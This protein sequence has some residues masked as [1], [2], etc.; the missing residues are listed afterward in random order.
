[1]NR[2]TL[3]ALFV[4]LTMVALV[5]GSLP[6][7]T[8][9]TSNAPAGLTETPTLQ[10]TNTPVPNT[11]VPNTP[12]PNTPV[13]NTPVPNTPVPNTPIPAPTNTPV[14]AR[15]D[16]PTVPAVVGLPNTGGAAQQSGAFPWALL[17]APPVVG[18]LVVLAFGLRIRARR[19][20]QQ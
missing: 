18:S 1:M 10:P 15:V 3:A 12:I 6:L 8:A 11:P 9:E 19:L 7:A 5:F 17:L 4:S 2:H 13:P 20:T 16:T 14:S